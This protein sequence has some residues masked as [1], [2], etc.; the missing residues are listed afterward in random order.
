LEPEK[1]QQNLQTL[2]RLAE[3][4]KIY[5]GY[6]IRIEGHAVQLLWWNEERAEEEQQ[7]TLIPLSKERAEAVKEALV[8][9]G[10]DGGRITT[11]GIGGADPVVPHGDKE[12]RWKNRRVEFILTERNSGS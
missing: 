7:E 11:K 8:E 12:N 1:V 5:G 10:V 6:E 9:R 2:D 4:L 3:I